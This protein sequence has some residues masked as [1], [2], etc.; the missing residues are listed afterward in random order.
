MSYGDGQSKAVAGRFNL[1]S[2][3][4]YLNDADTVEGLRKVHASLSRCCLPDKDDI[5]PVR[6][7]AHGIQRE[8]NCESDGWCLFENSDGRFGVIE[9][10]EDYTGHG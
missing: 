6:I 10:G 1:E 7:V 8:D 3:M 4:S 5:D 9:D 2:E